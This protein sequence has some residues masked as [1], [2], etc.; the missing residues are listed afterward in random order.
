MLGRLVADG[1]GPETVIVDDFSAPAKKRNYAS[2]PFAEAVERSAFW[3]WVEGREREIR[4]IVHLGARTD[5]ME[6]DPRVFEELNVAYTKA[7]WSL[8]ARHGIPLVYASSA[9]VYGGG[10][11][12]FHDDEAL[13]CRLRP[14]N[15]YGRSKQAVDAWVVGWVADAAPV[16]IYRATPIAVDLLERVR[17]QTGAADPRRESLDTSLVT[18]LFLLGRNDDTERL[19]RAVLSATRDPAVAGRMA[20]TL[21]YVLLRTVRAAEALAVL[22]EAGPFA[23]VWAARVQALEAMVLTQVDGGRP[24]EAEAAAREAEAAGLAAGDRLALGYGLHALSLVRSRSDR[25]PAGL[26]DV[27][28][29]ALDL[30]GDQPEAADLRLILLSNRIAALDNLGRPADAD[31][32]VREAVALAERAGTPQR[33]A[34]I[35]LIAAEHTYLGG[36]WDDTLAEVDVL[37]DLLPPGPPWSLMLH[38]VGALIAGHRDE[39]SAVDAHLDAVADLD[40]TTPDLRGFALYLIGAQSLAAER[41]GRAREALD[42]LFALLDPHASGTAYGEDSHLWL[43]EV[44]RLALAVDD[45]P[46]AR[47]AASWAADE[48]TER[49]TPGKLASTG[50]CEGLLSGDPEALTAVADRYERLD[51]PLFR[52]LA[53]E[54][55]A[56]AYARAGDTTSAH[57]AHAR[58]ID[59]YTALGAGWDVL[60]ADSRL[61]QLG[62]RRG[63]RGPRRRPASGWAALTPTELRI[64][65]LVAAGRSNPDIAVE[66]FLSRRTVQTH[67]SHILAK[68]GAQSRVEIAREVSTRRRGTAS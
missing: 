25:D 58:A 27:V 52:G 29:R 61:R 68:L 3:R 30:V 4:T 11:L 56:V 26:L 46:A 24:V 13:T 9:A 67:V 5:T 19:A 17:E 63:S 20:W 49:A 59:L 57:A 6:R 23:P 2:K 42:R 50:H 16:L 45:P 10:E 15:A 36:R 1:L 14:L 60:R 22:R 37:V 35:R 18:A 64:A 48:A 38:G 40:P 65:E 43:P 47:A 28:N 44:V 66:L 54:D 62:V 39:R 12:G 53:L 7:M 34:Q 21:G 8:A 51:L 31:Q 32:A 55:A 33:L 41:D